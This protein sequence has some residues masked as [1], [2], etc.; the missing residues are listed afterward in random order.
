MGGGGVIRCET[1]GVK[2]KVMERKK[3]EI[4]TNVLNITEVMD[5]LAF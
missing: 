3:T 5:K 2:S 1:A 4:K